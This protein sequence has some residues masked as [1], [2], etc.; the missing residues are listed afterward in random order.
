VQVIESISQLLLGARLISAI[1]DF[2]HISAGL[3]GRIPD[4]GGEYDNG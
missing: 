2:Q 4:K 3:C 1:A